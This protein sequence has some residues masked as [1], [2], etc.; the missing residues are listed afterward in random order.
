MCMITKYDK[1]PNW[2]LINHWSKR[3]TRKYLRNPLYWV[4]IPVIVIRKKYIYHKYNRT[5]IYRISS[6]CARYNIISV[7]CPF[8][9][10]ECNAFF[11]LHC[12]CIIFFKIKVKQKNISPSV[13]HFVYMKEKFVTNISFATFRLI[14]H[15]WDRIKCLA[16]WFIKN[17]F[18]LRLL[19]PWG[20]N[21]CL[22]RHNTF[23]RKF[24]YFF[25]NINHKTDMNINE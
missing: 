18:F 21:I 22:Y 6:Y 24:S 12:N 2:C 7:I 8:S 15:S 4:V 3:T 9:R 16:S 14:K 17:I 13:W 5:L 1:S 11:Y 19:F 20:G 10:V 23:K 25:F